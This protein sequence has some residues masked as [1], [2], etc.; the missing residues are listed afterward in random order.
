MHDVLRFWLDRGVDGFRMD[1]IHCIGKD[2]D[3]PDD[4]PEPSARLR[5]RRAQRRA[6]R[7]TRCCGASAACSTATPATGSPSARSTCSTTQ[8]DGRRTTA[9]ATSC[10][11]RSTSRRLFAPWRRRRVRGARS[12]AIEDVLDPATRWPTWVLSNHDNPRHRTRYGGSRPGPG[13]RPCCCSPCGARRSSTPARSSA[14]DDAVVPPDRVVD[15]GGR[16]GCRAPIPWTPTPDARL[17]RPTPWLPLPPEADERNVES[18]QAD[19]ALDPAPVPH[20]A[21]RAPGV[22]GPAR[23]ALRAARPR[24]RR[25]RPTSATLGRRSLAHRPGPSRRQPRSPCR[26]GRP[27]TGCVASDR[28]DRRGRSGV[29]CRR[30]SC[31][32]GRLRHRR[33]GTMPGR[34]R[35]AVGCQRVGRSAARQ[36]AD[37]HRGRPCRRRRGRRRRR[38]GGDVVADAARPASRGRSRASGVAAQQRVEVGAGGQQ[39]GVDLVV[40]GELADPRRHQRHRR[41]QVAVELLAVGAGRSASRLAGPRRPR[42]AARLPIVPAGVALVEAAGRA[43]G[44]AACAAASGRRR[45]GR[46]RAA[47]THRD[48]ARPRPPLAPGGHRPGHPA[49][50]RLERADLLQPQ[51]GAVG[52]GAAGRAGAQLLAPVERPTPRGRAPRSS[53]IEHVVQ[54]EQVGDVGGGVLALVVGERAAQ[55]VGQPVALGDGDLQLAR[56]AT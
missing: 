19:P 7:P 9:T 17:G 12:S 24:R 27:A 23:W 29:T 47:P 45:A 22:A 42:R 49:G 46:G 6:R 40:A 3:L 20:A 11:S 52:I 28:P 25:A 13:P 44:R 55:P 26:T 16:D 10:T 34:H 2:P 51:P 54:L 38:P 37:Q 35:T 15:P 48:V 8:R 18:R 1:V 30:R 33:R 53:A 36:V 56:T 5:P 21:G 14:C 4:P 43:P 39:R 41:P 32:A 50:S 31:R